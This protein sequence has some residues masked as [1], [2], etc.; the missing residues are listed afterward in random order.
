MFGFFL[1]FPVDDFSIYRNY[2]KKINLAF[3]VC[4]FLME[5]WSDC[6]IMII[7]ELRGNLKFISVWFVGILEGTERS[8]S[9][10]VTKNWLV[11]LRV[12]FL[13]NSY[14]PNTV[15]F[16]LITFFDISDVKFSFLNQIFASDTY[17]DKPFY[18]LSLNR[19]KILKPISH[20]IPINCHQRAKRFPTS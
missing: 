10:E 13:R 17:S 16:W 7:S 6:S 5:I 3:F 11:I 1:W 2:H 12:R 4:D 15:C 20:E 9:V 14:S 19:I 18:T 8:R